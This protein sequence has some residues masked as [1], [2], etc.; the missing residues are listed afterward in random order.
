MKNVLTRPRPDGSHFS[1]AKVPDNLVKTTVMKHSTI[2][3]F[4]CGLIFAAAPLTAHARPIDF[5]EVSLWVR[6]HQSEA[7]IK[8]DVAHRKLMHPLTPQ[9]ES[10]LKSQGASDSLVQSLRNSNYLASKDEVTATESVHAA[11]VKTRAEAEAVSSGP[12]VTV[13]NV[14]FGHSVNLSQWGGSD[15]EI[16]FYSYRVAGEDH[17]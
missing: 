9:Q 17:I 13:M 8:D 7:D 11:G 2:Y 1:I 12:H 16:A 15:Y 5:S 14:A 6:A 3:S 10:T 4:C